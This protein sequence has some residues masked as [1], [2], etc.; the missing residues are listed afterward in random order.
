MKVTP[1]TKPV[2]I[3]P[4]AYLYTDFR[5]NETVVLASHFRNGLR[6]KWKPLISAAAVRSLLEAKAKEWHI[7]SL[8]NFDEW[9]PHEREIEAELI[10][11]AQCSKELL[12]LA[13][14]LGNQGK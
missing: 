1:M 10:T 9:D 14:T 8:V 12:S 2:Q 6:D 4:V 5:D 11:L 13:A 3:Q 7:K